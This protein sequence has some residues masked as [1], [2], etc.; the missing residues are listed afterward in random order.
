MP[1]P[2]RIKKINFEV[3]PIY[4][5]E[6]FDGMKLKEVKPNKEKKKK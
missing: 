4:V 6:I 3:P 1:K 5:M 2:N